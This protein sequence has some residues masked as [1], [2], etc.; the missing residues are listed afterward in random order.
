MLLFAANLIM[1]GVIIARSVR[2]LSMGLALIL[3]D[4]VGLAGH[5][6]MPTDYFKNKYARIEPE[7]RLI[8]T[9]E[10]KAANVTIFQRPD[11]NRVLY[12]NGIPEVDTSY[13]SVRTLKL[14]GVLAGVASKR[15]NNALMVTFGAGITAG[16]TA[17][18]ADRVDCVDLAQQA[19]T[20]AGYFGPANGQVAENPKVNIH[21]DD[22][23]HYLKTSDQRY[24][25]IVSDATHPRPYDSWVLF[26]R[27]F[28]ELVPT[29]LTNEGGFC[30]WLP[31]HG[32]DE[33]QFISIIRTFA[34]VFPHT[35]LWREADA[36]IVLLATPTPLTIDFA[37]MT[38]KLSDPQV[39]NAVRLV[40]LNIPIDLLGSFSMGPSQLAHLTE[41]GSI[42]G[43]NT[44]AHLFFSFRATL[45]EQYRKWPQG[46]YRLLKQHEES[47]LPYVT[48]IGA[49]DNRRDAI[50][51]RIRRMEQI[52]R[53][54]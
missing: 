23:H 52:K 26:T 41:K 6:Y 35:S 21:V 14:L 37:H 18:F 45:A 17:L 8:Y 20:I 48:N 7:S 27:Q 5:I 53:R 40:D 36:Y 28:Y 24:A 3:I 4:G 54:F 9:S 47:V 12:I 11:G 32:M 25:I 44:P 31:L 1:G 34:S 43:D 49:D 51:N 38:A 46:N 15:P 22:A 42:I 19:R 13:L 30:Q 16:A 33:Q 39:F 50:V 2:R 10:G 29:R